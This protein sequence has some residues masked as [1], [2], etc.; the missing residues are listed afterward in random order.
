VTIA[1]LEISHPGVFIV[2]C[3]ALLLVAGGAVPR[4]RQSSIVAAIAVHLGMLIFQIPRVPR[5]PLL[6]LGKPFRP[7][8]TRSALRHSVTGFAFPPDHLPV[9]TDVLAV[10]AAKAAWK[11]PMSDVIRVLLPG[12][13]HIGEEV[14]VVDLLNDPNSLLNIA[15]P[16]VGQVR[17]VLPVKFPYSLTD[18]DES[19]PLGL[20]F[21]HK[22]LYS[23]SLDKGKFK[24]DGSLNQ[25]LVHALLR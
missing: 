18:R 3:N 7:M 6:T 9:L 13:L 10:M 11:V 12:H 15:Y 4:G 8:L 17:V 1:A 14:H 2:P 24:V 16:V 5:L 20:I 21:L 22:N 23:L 19:L 25:G